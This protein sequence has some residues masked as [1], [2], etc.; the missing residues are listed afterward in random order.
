M[1]ID[2]RPAATALLAV[3]LSASA[4]AQWSSNPALNLPLADNNN[5]SDQVQPKV[6]PTQNTGW[7]V[8]WFDSNPATTRPIGYDV[9]YQRLSNRGAEQF[10]HDGQMVADLTNSST[11]DYGLAMDTGGHAL[12]AFLDTREGTNQQITAAKMSQHGAPIW[13]TL[14]VQLTSDSSFHADPKIAGTS[15]GGIVVGWTSD[16]NVVLQKLNAAGQPQWGSGIV[17]SESGFNYT[18]ADLHAADNGSVILS[19]VRGAGF[20]SN[21]QLRANK[22]S[23]SGSILWGAGNVDIFDLGSLQFGNFPYFTYDGNGGAVFAWYTSSPTL[24]CFAQHIL[25]DGSEAFVHNGAAVSSNTTNIRVS[26]SAGY[27]PSTQEVF[28]FWTEEDSNQFFNGI[29]GQKFDS[30]GAPQWGA[31]GLTIIPLGNDSQIFATTVQ[32]GTG[33]LAFW[34]DEPSYGSSTIQA[35]KLDGSG[36]TICSQFPVS[37]TPSNKYGLSAAI[38]PGGVTALAF[39]DDRIGNNGIYIQNVNPNCSLGEPN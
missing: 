34:V 22:V 14:G 2:L 28:V 33:A 32:T 29:S 19:W 13:G 17:F 35:I 20:G 21:S 37:S 8:S 9:F 25:A 5:G 6:I 11:E 12:I 26:P 24:Q 16:S 27:R 31:D 18:L 30:T 7:Y 15:D 38:S 10:P 39:T 3:A 4:F 23:S 1:K 36:D